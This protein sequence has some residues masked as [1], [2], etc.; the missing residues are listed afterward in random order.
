MIVDECDKYELPDITDT[1][2]FIFFTADSW[3]RSIIVSGREGGGGSLRGFGLNPTN[4]MSFFITT[5]NISIEHSRFGGEG[6]W[7]SEPPDPCWI[8]HMYSI[9]F[10]ICIHYK[11][12]IPYYT[13]SLGYIRSQQLVNNVQSMVRKKPQNCIWLCK[14]Q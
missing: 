4:S 1:F 7:G 12:A 6:V 5:F 10:K 8:H 13:N 2:S 14:M 9:H 11:I 3:G